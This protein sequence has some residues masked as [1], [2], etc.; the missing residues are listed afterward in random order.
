MNPTF[1][2]HFFKKEKP[3]SFSKYIVYVDESGDH[4]LQNIDKNYP[5]FVFF[6]N[7]ITVNKLCQH[8]KNS[9]LIILDMIK[10]Y[11]INVK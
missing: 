9:S 4:G 1:K 2:N 8:L 10:L 5:Y 11:C 6:I 3:T 7:D